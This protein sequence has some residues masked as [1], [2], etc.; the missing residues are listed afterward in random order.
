MLGT[1]KS[2]VGIVRGE[3]GVGDISTLQFL[4]YYDVVNVPGIDQPQ[5]LREIVRM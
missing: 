2:F 5:R 4:K 3:G 1:F